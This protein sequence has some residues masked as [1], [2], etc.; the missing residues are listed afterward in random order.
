LKSHLAAVVV[1]DEGSR[2]AWGAWIEII[3]TKPEEL[4]QTSRP[5]WGAWIEMIISAEMA[6]ES[7]VAPRMGRVD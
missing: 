2:P 3:P 1:Q 7:F 5:A 4:T 6:K